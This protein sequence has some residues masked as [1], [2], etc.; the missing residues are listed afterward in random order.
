MAEI[1]LN[2]KR[3]SGDFIDRQTAEAFAQVIRR[4]GL[5]Q[6]IDLQS[7]D[8]K[9]FGPLTGGFGRSRIPSHL[10]NDPAQYLRFFDSRCETRFGTTYLAI[11]N[12]DSGNS[13][14]EV[15]RASTIFKGNLWGLWQ[16]NTSANVVFRYYDGS[17]TEWAGSAGLSTGGPIVCL[18]LISHKTRMVALIAG[19]QAGGAD[20]DHRTFHSTD[21]S[22]WTES[23]T[24]ITTALLSNNITANEDINAGMLAS[25]GNELVAVVWH[26]AGGTITFFSS[27]DSATTWVDEAVDI[28]SGNGPLGV[29]VYPGIDDADKLYV[30]TVEGLYEVD[31]SPGTWT[32]HQ[33]E[34][35]NSAGGDDFNC[36]R[37]V[38]HE[39][40]LW[41][42]LGTST[43]APV[44]IATM[45]TSGG[46]RLFNI[47]MGL[48]VMDGVPSDMLGG[49]HWMKSVEDMLYITVGGEAA[50]RNGRILCYTGTDV[51]GFPQ[52]HHMFRNSTANQ[53]VQWIDFSTR[54]DGNARLHFAMRTAAAT[55]DT[56]FLADPNT[57]PASGIGGKTQASGIIDYP[58]MDGGMPTIPGIILQLRA[59]A[60]ELSDSTSG[61][62]IA[63]SYGV[64]EE[65]RTVNTNLTN[66]ANFESDDLDL[67]V[68]SGA[69]LA[70]RSFGVRLTLNRDGTTDT[71]TP[72]LGSMEIDYMKVPSLRK[73]FLFEVDLEKTARLPGHSSTE[74]VIANINAAE[75]LTVLPALS[76]SRDTTTYVKV[77]RVDDVFKLREG[78]GPSLRRRSGTSLIYMEEPL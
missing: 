55:S 38:V 69:G 34:L 54:D 65:A 42:A 50:N 48:N 73:R 4:Q 58:F 10:S 56:E 40:K 13:G 3:Y 37:L 52:W 71:D 72:E 6:Q 25:I 28:G 76:Y 70:G 12:E 19:A 31:T 30:L 9:V 26:E 5:S 64:N 11:L 47:N 17:S 15:M 51:N 59:D 62:Y 78:S 53:E 60:R 32:I 44:K 23:S 2:S 41:I 74:Q 43:S 75:A 14:L 16:D 68:A 77:T 39:G 20:N 49:V 33:T 61:E 21:G 27:T 35:R 18:D 66:S 46:T 45:D 22:T 36:R 63:A 8:S 67:D 57:N 29:A 7:P 24:K 1:T